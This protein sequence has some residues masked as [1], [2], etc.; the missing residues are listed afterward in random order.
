MKTFSKKAMSVMLAVLMIFSIAPLAEFFGIEANAASESD[1]TFTL[2]NNGTEYEVSSCKKWIEGNLIIPSTHNGKS[3][4]R[5]GKSALEVTNLVSII[6]PDSVTSIGEHA[7]NLSKSLKSITIPASVTSIDGYPFLSC[8]ALESI[9]VDPENEYFS[10]ED[11]VLFNKN[12]TVLIEYPNGNAR[13][14]YT[15]PNG[16][17]T[18]AER[19]FQYSNNLE[20]ISFPDSVTVLGE[21]A[22]CYCEALK[23]VNI[24]S[25][26]T[27]MGE[28]PAFDNC[29]TLESINV[30]PENT[31]FSSVDGVLFNKDKTKLIT[32][33]DGNSKTSYVIPNGVTEIG[34]YAFTP[35]KVLES[36]TIP[37]SVK[38]ISAFAFEG[39]EALKSI[40]LPNSI[41]NIEKAAF[42]DC[43][44]LESIVIP[45]SVTS[46]G[47]SIFA[48]CSS[49]K[50][51][52]LPKGITVITGDMFCN[53]TALESIDIPDSVTEI[54]SYAFSSCSSIKSIIVP[55]GVK[56]IDS[57]AFKGCASLKSI[58]FS[59]SVEAIGFEAFSFCNSLETVNFFGTKSDWNKIEIEEGNNCLEEAK[60][61]YKN[62][63]FQKIADFFNNI[64]NAISS[65]FNQIFKR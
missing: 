58:T 57:F 26:V 12:K 50:N 61:T 13:T 37:D 45:D 21:Y 23:S 49:L 19:G 27:N 20:S 62:D 24:P 10:S 52:S 17:T 51:V 7:F 34:E 59:N 22:F 39:C 42:L 30:D 16:V 38:T 32:Y 48:Y 40:Q 29:T 63:F 31:Y 47:E 1:L 18:I 28:W 60:R 35:S 3:V 53:C 65:F 36:I 56:N 55:D 64:F 8:T 41:T 44:A 43:T 11:G 5:I 54:G 9:N 46:M 25:G 2:I 15:I 4:T 6:I 33:P 14:S